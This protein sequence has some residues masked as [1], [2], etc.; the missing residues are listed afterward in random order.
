MVQ[1]TINLLCFPVALQKATENAHTADPEQLLWHASIGSTFPFAKTAVTSLTTCLGVL[2]HSGARVHGHRLLNDQA[3][4]DQFTDVLPCHVG[5]KA[6]QYSTRKLCN[7]QELTGIGIG[8][9]INFVWVEPDLAT[10]AFHYRC[11]QPLL[12]P[13]VTENTEAILILHVMN[14][15]KKTV[16]VK[17]LSIYLDNSLNDDGENCSLTRT[18]RPVYKNRNESRHVI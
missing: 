6:C 16:L 18:K 15:V 12:K 8:N 1:V 9:F 2:P 11:G 13:Q 3:I 10:T 4:L 5:T 17:K 14:R 7:K